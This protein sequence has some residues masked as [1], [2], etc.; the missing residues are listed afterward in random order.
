MTSD[1]FCHIQ[2]IGRADKKLDRQ[3]SSEWS[4]T[5]V[6]QSRDF[7]MLVAAIRVVCMCKP[8]IIYTLCLYIHDYRPDLL[9][10]NATVSFCADDPVCQKVSRIVWQKVLMICLWEYLVG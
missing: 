2:S 8:S 4:C 7:V 6:V 3:H 9:I 5:M 1:A 10:G